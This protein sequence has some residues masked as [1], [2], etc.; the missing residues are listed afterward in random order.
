MFSRV[1]NDDW[2]ISPYPGVIDILVARN[3]Q[4]LQIAGPEMFIP[5]SCLLCQSG[6]ILSVSL[7]PNSTSAPLPWPSCLFSLGFLFA[8]HYY[9]DF[10]HLEKWTDFTWNFRWWMRL[11]KICMYELMNIII[12]FG[13]VEA[14]SLGAEG[15]VEVL[16]Y[17]QFSLKHFLAL[18]CLSLLPNTIMN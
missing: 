14:E 10:A 6:N 7:K 2:E 9:V 18:K 5:F 4:N 8:L 11:T 13:H 16:N 12:I 1:K 17:S 15:N 3:I